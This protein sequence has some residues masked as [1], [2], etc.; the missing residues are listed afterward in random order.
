[1]ALLEAGLKALE[2]S[3]FQDISLRQLARDTNVSAT[4]VYRHFPDKQA[5][6]R[7]LAD[8][9][10]ARLGQYQAAAIASREPGID[11]FT[12]NGRAYVRFALANPGLFRTAFVYADAVGDR[13][14]GD[15]MPA[16][17][18]TA[19]T[20]EYAQGDP[21]EAERLAIQAWATV[22]GLAMLMLEGQLPASPELI[23]RIVRPGV[24]LKPQ[25]S[26]N[27]ESP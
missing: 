20:G 5:L 12:A 11:P 21:Q 23:D 15:T 9:G 22:H 27:E 17:L 2:T 14:F 6:L 18:L 24:I 8:E 4:A 25:G 13:I 16:R 10:I 7:A 3:D 19:Q 1:M 26:S